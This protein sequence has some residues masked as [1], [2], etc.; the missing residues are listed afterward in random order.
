MKVMRANCRVQFTAED[1]AFVAAT[2][3]GPA[4]QGEAV[5]RLLADPDTRDL[6]LD[7]RAL[8]QAL[9]E[10]PAC[11]RVSTH[12]Y[13][14]ILVRQVLRRAGLEDRAVADYVAELLAEYSQAGRA[15]GLNPDQPAPWEDCF[16]LLAAL[17]K[18]DDR[19][20]FSLRAHLGNHTLFLTGIFPQYLQWRKERRAAPGL[21]YYEGLGQASFR[22]ASGHRLA[23]DYDLAPIFDTLAARFRAARE[24]LNDLS[25]RLLTWQE[26]G[27][28]PRLPA[29][30]SAAL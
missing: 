13:F 10:Q 30:D 28:W 4:G 1:V 29:Q 5:V 24:A 2:L 25:E 16:D 7:D 19:V 14:Y 8:F 6:V 27:L 15:R 22:A 11:L 17:K 12:F 23:Q 20:A 26:A 18:V 9:L 3:G 21:E